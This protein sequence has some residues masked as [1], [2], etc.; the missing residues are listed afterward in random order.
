MKTKKFEILLTEA[1]QTRTIVIEACDMWD[2][3]GWLR[4]RI[5]ECEYGE[6]ESVN[7]KELK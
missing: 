7:V 1:S 4:S 2:A 3:L 5:E 6:P